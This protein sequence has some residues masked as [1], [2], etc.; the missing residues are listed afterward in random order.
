VARKAE[1]L[2][3]SG[4]WERWEGGSW[5][6]IIDRELQY[7]EN[8]GITDAISRLSRN[9]AFCAQKQIR[10]Q[11][12]HKILIILYTFFWHVRQT[13]TGEL[14]RVKYSDG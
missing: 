10:E 1:V 8:G 2:K 14:V 11:E 6:S 4:W 7:T 5:R 3:M 9:G 13:K 12:T